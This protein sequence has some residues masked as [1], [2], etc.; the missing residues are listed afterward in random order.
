MSFTAALL[1]VTVAAT[2]GVL[3]ATGIAG[4]IGLSGFQFMMVQLTG[5]LAGCAFAQQ[6]V[7]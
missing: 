2:A 5:A 7:G 3:I 1:A 6:I 4:L